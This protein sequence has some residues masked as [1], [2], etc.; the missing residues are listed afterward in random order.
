MVEYEHTAPT[1]VAL[2]RQAIAMLQGLPEDSPQV[3]DQANVL[4]HLCKPRR[5]E[6]IRGRPE[7]HPAWLQLA[8]DLD[9]DEVNINI[10]LERGR[11]LACGVNQIHR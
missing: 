9:C 11:W 5:K 10:R 1:P 6:T 8:M 4:V 3:R 7:T 2:F